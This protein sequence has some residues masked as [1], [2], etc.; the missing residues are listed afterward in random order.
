MGPDDSTRFFLA[1]VK[2]GLM[3]S[4]QLSKRRQLLYWDALYDEMTIDEWEAV[5]RQAMKAQNFH[6]IPLP[7]VL[8][9]Y[10]KEARRPKNMPYLG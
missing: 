10:A 1:L 6:K 4:D 5:T 3:F 2:M 8:I 7:A 9:D